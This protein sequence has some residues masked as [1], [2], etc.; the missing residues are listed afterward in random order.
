MTAPF[1]AA[2]CSRAT[3]RGER[4]SSPGATLCA[5]RLRRDRPPHAGS[6]RT[7]QLA[8]PERL[9]LRNNRHD[10]RPLWAVG[11]NER[12]HNGGGPCHQKGS[13][14][15]HSPGSPANGSLRRAGR[16]WPAPSLLFPFFRNT[17]RRA[18]RAHPPCG[19]I[20]GSEG[21]FEGRAYAAP[22]RTRVRPKGIDFIGGPVGLDSTVPRRLP[23]VT[24]HGA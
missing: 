19:E 8:K 2:A 4:L 20:G 1:G 13:A 6:L 22:R 17:G 5:Q 9:G 10:A 23:F 7:R 3:R 18:G 14:I 24:I 12:S 21:G 16:T 15:D 11:P